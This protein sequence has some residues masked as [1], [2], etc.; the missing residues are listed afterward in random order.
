M[1]P[2]SSTTN[3][4]ALATRFRFAL[5]PLVRQL[6]HHNIDLTPSQASALASISRRGPLTVGDL[7]KAEHV[8]SPMITKICP[9]RTLK[10]TSLCTTC[11]P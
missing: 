11:S 2:T 9:W 10:A 7:A 3:L 1:A 4:T 5:F 6:R 8:S